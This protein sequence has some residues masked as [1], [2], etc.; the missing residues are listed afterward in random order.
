[1]KKIIY[2]LLFLFTISTVFT[3]CREKKENDVEEVIDEAGDAVEDAADEVE[4]EVE[5]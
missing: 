3:G 5:Q 2:T 4:D 1:M